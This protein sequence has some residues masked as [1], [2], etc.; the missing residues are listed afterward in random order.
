[1]STE[2]IARALIGEVPLDVPRTTRRQGMANLREAMGGQPAFWG[3]LQQMLFGQKFGLRGLPPA[4]VQQ[5]MADQM[6]SAL[7][8][9]DA[10]PR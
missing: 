3:P 4:V 10:V 6:G 2:D 8:I 5:N 9:S 7:G 1:M